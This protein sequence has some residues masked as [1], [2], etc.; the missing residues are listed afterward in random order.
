MRRLLSSALCLSIALLSAAL[1]LG[2]ETNSGKPLDLT[3]V[4]EDA[5]AA[6]VGHPQQLLTGPQAE[7]LP[8]EV[9]S[10]AVKKQVGFDPLELQEVMGVVG[11]PDRAAS[12]QAPEPRAGFVLR[13]RQ[14]IAAAVVI[15]KIVPDGEDEELQGR[16]LRLNRNR[17]QFSC[18]MADDR[19]LLVAPEI[20]LRWILTAPHGDSPL[21][22][23]LAAADDSPVGVWYL[24]MEP[25]RPLY[26]QALAQA[27]QQIPPP[28]M[29]FT[30]IPDLMDSLVA[31]ATQS[32]RGEMHIEVTATAPDEQAATQLEKLIKQ[33]MEIG[34]SMMLAGMSESMSRAPNED[35]DVTAAMMKYMKRLTDKVA[36]SLQPVREGK[37]VIMRLNSPSGPASVAVLTALLLPAVQAA[38]GGGTSKRVAEQFEGNRAS[39]FEF[40]IGPQADAGAGDL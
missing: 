5:V 33:A 6:F 7:M 17:S 37:R 18:A 14:P 24:A 23:M 26:H 13:F 36:A 16:R 31:S 20:G 12:G 10:V 22:K 4:P 1:T 29:V 19:T 2:D 28:L 39:D 30:K 9:I 11:L 32:E 8:T 27:G 38:Q 35:P 21:R 34:K 3:F 25:L 40:R 15:A